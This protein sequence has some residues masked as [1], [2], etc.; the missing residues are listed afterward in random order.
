MKKG[1]TMFSIL[2][3]LYK[4]KLDAEKAEDSLLKLNLQV[5]KDCFSKR[6]WHNPKW[7][8]RRRNWQKTHLKMNGE[9]ELNFEPSSEAIRN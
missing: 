6:L 8:W 3:M 2:P 4:A 1:D 9:A 5:L 7:A